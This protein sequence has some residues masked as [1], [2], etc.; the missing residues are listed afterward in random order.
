M[1]ICYLGKILEP[2]ED[3]VLLD[4]VIKNTI[5]GPCG[6]YKL[7]SPCMTYGMYLVKKYTRRFIA[8]QVRMGIHYIVA[9]R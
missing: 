2:T 1:V 4:N 8:R 3:L 7:I 5:H 6:R 9:D